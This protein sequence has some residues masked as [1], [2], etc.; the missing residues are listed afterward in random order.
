MDGRRWPSGGFDHLM[1]TNVI[2]G[3]YD[4]VLDLIVDSFGSV[5]AAWLSVEVMRPPTAPESGDA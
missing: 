3:K 4:T 5:L 2:K 1:P